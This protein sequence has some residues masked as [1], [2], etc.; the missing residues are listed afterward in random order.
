MISMKALKSASS[1][2]QYYG[3]ADDYYAGEGSEGAS[4]ER[5]GSQYFGKG[6]EALGLTDGVNQEQLKALLEGRLPN[7]EQLGRV[8]EGGEIEHK[9]GWDLTF[10]APKSVSVLALVGGDK[11]LMDAHKESVKAALAYAEAN[12]IASREQKNGKSQQVE[13]GNMVAALFT[14]TTSRALDPQLHTHS[15]IINATARENGD[16]RSVESKPLYENSMLLGQIY[17]SELAMRAKELGYTIE[18]GKNGTF[19]L[20]EVPESVLEVFSKRDRKSVV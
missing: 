5:Q 6:A 14:H 3:Q 4:G 20:A 2:G 10:S 11:S 18:V 12:L 9:P 1:A 15:V 8:R 7:G 16:W 17:R 19:E 13:T